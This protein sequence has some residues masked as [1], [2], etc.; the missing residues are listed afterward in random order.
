MRAT[1]INNDGRVSYQ[2]DFSYH[3]EH[4]IIARFESQCML[5]EVVWAKLFFESTG[6]LIASYDVLD[7][8]VI[9]KNKK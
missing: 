4:D 5:N 3:S 9:K 7:G 1:S 2:A 8:L 6:E